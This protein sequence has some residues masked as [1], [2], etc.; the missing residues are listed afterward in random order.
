M[1]RKLFKS[2][3]LLVS[4]VAMI[5]LIGCGTTGA[6]QN[7]LMTG[8]GI[9][10]ALGAGIGAAVNSSNP[11]KGA[12]VGGLLGAATGAIG[13]EVYRRTQQPAQPQQGYNQYGP[14]Q[15]GYGYPPP[16]QGYYRG[17]NYGPPAYGQSGP[18]PV[19]R[20]ARLRT[21]RSASWLLFPGRAS[22]AV[23]FAAFA[24]YNGEPGYCPLGS[25][26]LG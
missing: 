23:V 25:F 4:G 9:G 13:G 21:E 16:N 18:P 12:A 17:P 19:I 20:S 26:F 15:P 2:M 8:G 10:T 6:P 3:M 5:S 11:W 22:H 24:G 14:Q 7:Y 1:K